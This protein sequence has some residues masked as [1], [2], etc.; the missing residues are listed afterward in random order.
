MKKIYLF[1]LAAFMLLGFSNTTN[2]QTIWAGDPITFTK[3]NNVDFNLEAN[4]DRITDNVWIT[5]GN[6]SGLYNIAVETGNFD[7]CDGPEPT[8][9]EWAYGSVDNID[10][11]TFMPIGSLIGC[12]F[13]NIV[14]GQPMVL[15]LI[16]DDIYISLTFLSWTVGQGGGG[17]GG[18]GFSYTRSTDDNVISV[19]EN[20]SEA[21][22]I[23]PNPTT[24]KIQ[25]KG[26]NAGE[27]FQ[28]F[29]QAGKLITEGVL[30]D[31]ATI[32][33]NEFPNG[34]YFVVMQGGQKMSFVKK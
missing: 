16:T 21:L 24:E 30:E 18:G 17:P 32:L 25:I 2:G 34:M 5:R 6:S 10:N 20:A 28:I 31:N 4:Q 7:A 9:T 33:V 27:S 8:D 3:D 22:A 11:L 26:A 1:L 15:H 23:L 19:E 13:Q 29:N 14:D 12:D